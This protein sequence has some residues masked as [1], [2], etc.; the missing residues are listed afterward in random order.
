LLT[1]KVST[2]KLKVDE[3]YNILT[4]QWSDNV[5]NNQR[6]PVPTCVGIDK[7]D[8]GFLNSF[9]KKFYDVPNLIRPGQSSVFDRMYSEIDNQR[10]PC[11]TTDSQSVQS[12]QLLTQN[13]VII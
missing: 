12:G 7:P 3:L 1:E 11:M 6:L 5:L 10:I 9:T 2:L 8:D 13:N 4:T